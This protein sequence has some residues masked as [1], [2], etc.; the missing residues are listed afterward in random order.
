VAS[1]QAKEL[2]KQGIAAAKA[3]QTEQARSLLQ[4]A[5]R[6]DPRNEAAWLW[7]ISLARDTR[8][9]MVFLNRLLDIN[10]NNEMGLKALAD[11]NLTRDQLMAQ[12]S[13]TVAKPETRSA[14]AQAAQ[15][16]GVPIADQQ[17]L[18]TIAPEVDQIVQAYV[19]QTFD[20][21]GV[22]WAQKTK[23]RL[24]EADIW[25]VR[26][27]VGAIAAVVLLV[28]G[29]GG[30]AAVLSNPTLRG[31]VFVPTPTLTPTRPPPTFT[32]TP[33]PG[34]TPTPS[35]TPELTLTPSPTV[36]PEIPNG[37]AAAPEPTPLYPPAFERSLQE[38]VSLL[39]RERY[40]EALPTL[41]MEITAVSARFDPAPYYYTALSMIGSGELAQAKQILLDGQNRLT[42]T[43]SPDERAVIVG[44]L[45]YVNVLLAEQA[46]KLGQTDT[47]STLLA[48]AEAQA[49]EALE[50]NPGFDLPYLAEARRLVLRNSTDAAIEILDQGLGTEQLRSNTRLI[51]AKGELYF[52]RGVYDLAAYQA[53]LALYIDPTTESAHRLRI[54]TALAEGD[55]G[56]GVLYSQ[57]YLFY[58]PGSAEGFRLLGDAR[59]A[60]GNRDL[61]LEAY[62]QGLA[63]GDDVELLLAR[64][65]L[66]RQQN[67][68]NQARE[69]LTTA[70]ALSDDPAIRVLRMQAA[71]EGG[72]YAIAQD[73]ADALLGSGAIPDGQL[74]LLQA[75]ILIDQ[76]APDDTA[77]YEQALDLLTSPGEGIE[78]GQQPLI[79]EYRARAYYGLEQYQNALDTVNAALSDAE[80]GSR[81]Y[82]RG[83]IWEA[84]G[85][86]TLA[87][88]D[89]EWV[90]SWGE[91]YP[92]PFLPDVRER[93]AE[94]TGA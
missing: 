78:P 87:Q 21:P 38:A 57:A 92:Y 82:L 64:A 28:V 56:S 4:Q 85:E 5:I 24:G 54:R 67:R 14:Q 42:D 65:A 71:Y 16:E 36:P 79:N 32:P 15:V 86:N 7:M 94:L 70:F 74:R 89:Y 19:G 35:P 11:M 76:A 93:Y 33:T 47:L 62:T 61:A 40:E 53:F 17:R 48:D 69:D 52:E 27:V 10:S 18:N 13:S 20:Y 41:E 68:Y 75:R 3:G 46:R 31:I 9:K 77:T 59:V 50:Q 2:R 30:Y 81:Y 90:L 66:Y 51:V 25:K 37:N 34:V 83:L 22:E 45:A 55:A 39:D 6:L 26:A 43:S 72:Q 60:E 73:D 91:I 23:G 1:D 63:G 58:Y 49:E 29:I 44:G 12:V 84:R 88:R 8:E 80:T